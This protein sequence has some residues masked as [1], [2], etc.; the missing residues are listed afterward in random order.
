MERARWAQAARKPE[1]QRAA[2]RGF[3]LARTLR[4]WEAAPSRRTPTDL[5]SGSRRLGPVV[6]WA[7][8]QRA[9]ATRLAARAAV[10]PLAVPKPGGAGRR[11]VRA[12]ARRRAR[13]GEHRKARAVR[14]VAA[15]PRWRRTDS[16]LQVSRL[17]NAEAL[18]GRNR[19]ARAV[20]PTA[21]VVA[22]QV[23]APV[24]DNL[25][26]GPIVAAARLAE[27]AARIVA[28]AAVHP[29]AAGVARLAEEAARSAEADLAGSASAPPRPVLR[30]R[31]RRKKGR[32][33]WWAD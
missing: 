32:I 31:A 26:A 20:R 8:Q 33:C 14:L 13:G 25:A 17:G 28:V 9:A 19:V 29:T 24:A 16:S 11:K 30:P 18:P 23:R 2:L 27:E 6:Q 4:E 7:A 3:A 5:W 1:A 15:D 12:A 10:V 21:E 22:R